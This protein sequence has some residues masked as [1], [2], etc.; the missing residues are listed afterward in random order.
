M[1]ILLTHYK[2]LSS[3]SLCLPTELLQVGFFRNNKAQNYEAITHNLSKQEYKLKNLF[4]D[5]FVETPLFSMMLIEHQNFYCDSKNGENEDGISFSF[6]K[7]SKLLK[8]LKLKGNYTIPVLIKKLEQFVTKF[9]SNYFC[10]DDEPITIFEDLFI[11]PNRCTICYNFSEEFIEYLNK[12]KKSLTLIQNQ[13]FIFVK[14]KT[15]VATF[16]IIQS[17]KGLKTPFFTKRYLTDILG[18]TGDINKKLSVALTGLKTKHAIEY[19]KEVCNIPGINSSFSRFNIEKIDANFVSKIKIYKFKKIKN[20]ISKPAQTKENKTL[21]PKAKLKGKVANSPVYTTSACI[22]S[23]VISFN[24]FKS[25]KI[26]KENESSE[27]VKSLEIDELDEAW[28]LAVSGQDSLAFQSENGN[29]G[30]CQKS[31]V[32]K[33]VQVFSPEMM[34]KVK[35][36]KFN[37]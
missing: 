37:F 30:V 9:R 26:K 29:F 32:P 19:K 4:C 14:G 11:N 28:I 16:L 15:Q 21:A 35:I 27:N 20:D 13:D 12:R 34:S 10:V 5:T 2:Y 23:N 24:D 22:K 18:I 36:K 31:Q 1:T 3:Q 33:D 17:L 7:G 8:Q 6:K 25:K